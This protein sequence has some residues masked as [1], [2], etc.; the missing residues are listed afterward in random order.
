MSR[1]KN[2]IIS[3]L[4]LISILLYLNGY[5]ICHFIY[6]SEGT[7]GEEK[8]LIIKSYWELRFSLYSVIIAISFYISRFSLSSFNKTLVYIGFDLAL[9][10]SIDKLVLSKFDVY[11][12]EILLILLIVIGRFYRYLKKRNYENKRKKLHGQT[13]DRLR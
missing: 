12:Y 1:N 5:R 6:N 13:T 2:I 8:E 3:I 11:E 4:I 9:I 10:S 7:Q